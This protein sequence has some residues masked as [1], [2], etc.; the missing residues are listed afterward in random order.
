MADP[1]IVMMALAKKLSGY[2]ALVNMWALVHLAQTNPFLRHARPGHYNSPLP[3]INFLQDDAASSRV[4]NTGL[5][6]VPGID[7]RTAAQLQ[8]LESCRGFLDEARSGSLWRRYTAPNNW[9]SAGD[10]AIASAMLRSCRPSRVVEAGSGFSSAAMLD[11][12]ERCLDNRVRFTFIEPHP[13]RLA[14]VLRAKD[15]AAHEVLAVR[16]QDVSLN[17]FRELQRD[18]ILFIDSSHVV[19]IASDVNYFLAEVLPALSAGVVVHIHDIYW[20]FEYPRQWLLD[21]RAWNEVYAVR[22]FLQFNARFEILYFSD[23]M[24]KCHADRLPPELLEVGSLWLR[25]RG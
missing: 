10:A 16:A 13:Q 24:A 4:F 18:D 19:K 7:L 1:F 3:D 12:S 9:Y 17:V 2:S 22:A 5:R 11:T 14:T 25:V 20:P 23:Y 6:D 8:W 15:S 21:G